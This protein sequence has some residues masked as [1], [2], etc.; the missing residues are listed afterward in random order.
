KNEAIDQKQDPSPTYL[1]AQIGNAHELST[2]LIEEDKLIRTDSTFG[3]AVPIKSALKLSANKQ[4]HELKDMNIGI[5]GGFYGQDQQ[6]NTTTLGFEGSD[7]SA[8]L[9]GAATGAVTIDI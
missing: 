9:V 3:N 4:F 8:S 6:G 7:Y 1:P 2:H 5:M